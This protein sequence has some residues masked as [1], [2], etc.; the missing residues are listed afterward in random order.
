MVS[1][2]QPGDLYVGDL[3]DLVSVV[4]DLSDR[5]SAASANLPEEI[6]AHRANK[7]APLHWGPR[8]VIHETKKQRSDRP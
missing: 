6:G 5:G 7:S 4:G 2:E 8:M 3:S 1:A